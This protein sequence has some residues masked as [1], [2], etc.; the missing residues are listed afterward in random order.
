MSRRIEKTMDETTEEMRARLAARI[1][2]Y[3]DALMAYRLA[4]REL[5]NLESSTR[6][7][8]ARLHAA[9]DAVDD[10]LGLER[11]KRKAER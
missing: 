8:F 10:L 2:T 7:A 3:R 1:A 9:E 4:D 5:C 6:D 11:I